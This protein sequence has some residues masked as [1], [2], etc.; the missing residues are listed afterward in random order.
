MLFPREYSL[1]NSFALKYLFTIT[2]YKY[3]SETFCVPVFVLS[4]LCGISSSILITTHHQDEKLKTEVKSFT[5]G[6]KNAELS[7]KLMLLIML[8]YPTLDFRIVLPLLHLFY[9]GQS[10]SISCFCEAKCDPGSG[11]R[12]SPSVFLLHFT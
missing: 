1:R 4:T 8:P 3:Q 9:K 10:F 12:F 6:C 7:S 2:G 5:Q 11:S